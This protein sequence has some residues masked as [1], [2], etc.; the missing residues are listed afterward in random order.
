MTRS[1]DVDPSQAPYLSE[2]PGRP[3][4]DYSLPPADDGVIVDYGSSGASTGESGE[5]EDDAGPPPQE[6]PSPR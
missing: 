2:E 1:D 4:F 5:D 6:L 3:D